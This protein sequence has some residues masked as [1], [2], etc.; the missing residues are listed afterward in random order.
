MMAERPSP[1]VGTP[2]RRE[3][4]PTRPPVF[5]THLARF[6]SRVPVSTSPP[7]APLSPPSLSHPSRS[8][9]SGTSAQRRLARLATP[10]D[11]RDGTASAR[12]ATPPSRL[13]LAHRPP[14]WRGRRVPRPA[15]LALP[16]RSECSLLR[17]EAGR[18]RALSRP[19]RSW[20]SLIL[21]GGVLI[22]SPLCSTRVRS[23]QMP[24]S[25]RSA[26]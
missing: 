8:P 14:H 24:S 18:G 11:G 4:R 9:E 17:V 7:L 21:P 15:S 20:C 13:P 23:S 10:R 26:P 19:A 6:R 2:D 22:A 25:T 3:S 12:L 1:R 16:C 5:K